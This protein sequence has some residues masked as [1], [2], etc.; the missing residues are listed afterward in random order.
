MFKENPQLWRQ[1]AIISIFLVTSTAQVVFADESVKTDWSS[2]NLS[3]VQITRNIVSMPLAFTANQGQWDE[4]VKFRANAGGAA[5]WFSSDGAYYQFTRTIKSEDSAPISVVR[6][7]YRMMPDYRTDR[8]P[9]PVETMMIK[10]SFVGANTNP[11]MHGVD[12]LKYKCNYFIGNDPNEWHTNVPNYQA[13]V[14]Q[15]LYDGIDLKYYGNGK[16]MEYDFIVSPGADY[17]QIKIH[18]EGAESIA[19]NDNGELVVTTMWGD[20]VERRPVIYQIENNSRNVIDGNYILRADNSFG[21]E[22][23]DYNPALPLVIDP[24]LSYSTYLGGSSNDYGYGMAVDASG[25]VYLTGSTESTNFPTLNPYQGTFQGFSDIF[26]T[27][28]S[29]SGAS[30]VYSTYLGGNNYDDGWS[31]ALDS[32][33][34]AYITGVT[35]STDF[36]TLNAYQVTYQGGLSDAFITK[37]SSTGDSLI[38]SGYLGGSDY[39]IAYYIALDSSG[40]AY[41]TGLTFSTDFPT[42]NPYQSTPQSGSDV[43]VTKLSSSG[44]SLV[45]STYLGGTK[46][47]DGFSIAVDASGAAYITG[48]TYSTDFPTLNPYQGTF[49]GFSEAYV[50]KLSSSGSSL[51]YS[52]YLGGSS[53]DF[54]IDIA[55]DSSG[56]AYITGG[57][58]SPDFPTLN[59]YQGT[60]RD[61]SDA[62]VTKLS[63][64]GDSLVYSTYLG[65]NNY[66]EGY[67]IVLDASGAAYIT[68]Y[69]EST[70]FPTLNPYQGTFQGIADAFVAKLSSSGAS[71]DYSTYLGGSLY[72]YGSGIAL[73]SSGAVYVMGETYSTDFPTLNP[74]QDTLMGFVNA[75]VM[76]FSSFLTDVEEFDFGNLPR[77]YNLSQN[78]PNPFNP[79]TTI[80]FNIPKRSN[81]SINIY[82]MLGQKVKRLINQEYSAGNYKITW[83]GTTSNGVRASTGL[84][85]YRLETKDFVETKKM[86]LLK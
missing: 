46:Y 59:P 68:G 76:K 26:I 60:F 10:A 39:D 21:F 6:K 19:I 70:N 40:A 43:F 41:V 12:E 42:L 23:S 37:L 44:A 27:K 25:A 47:D 64:S 57:T 48:I 52:T 83:D 17:S 7:R 71:L 24:V 14:Y 31:I 20:V 51:V 82:N 2:A 28:L 78:Y 55:V 3:S 53:E 67:S 69:T 38:Y 8:Q 5:M 22:L 54:G 74:Y 32:S 79:T 30:L 56:A 45:Y 65:G 34:S 86:I 50:T 36:P 81:A 13:V 80:D 72:E 62:F 29:S 61:S 73:G 35:Y 77:D 18:Y 16:Q 15:E 58:Y 66:D 1:I 49:Q 63:S 75:F 9:K 11:I 85:F 33:G 4:R 84:Y